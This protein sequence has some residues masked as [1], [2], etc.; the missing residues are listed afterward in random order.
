MNVDVASLHA[1]QYTWNWRSV[2]GFVVVFRQVIVSEP[3]IVRVAGSS[4][5]L[6]V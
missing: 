2:A 6:I 5:A 4:V 3:V 1:F